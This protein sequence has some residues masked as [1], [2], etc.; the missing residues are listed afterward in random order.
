MLLSMGVVGTFATLMT[1]W[2][3]HCSK[4]RTFTLTEKEHKRILH[5]KEEKEKEKEEQVAAQSLL[6]SDGA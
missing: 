5:E 4:E 3:N 1:I 2:T 6:M